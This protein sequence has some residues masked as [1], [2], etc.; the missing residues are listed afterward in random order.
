MAMTPEM[1]WEACLGQLRMDMSKASYDTWLASAQLVSFEEHTF[2]IG[3]DNSYGRDWLESRLTTT[4]KR[5]LGGMLNCTVQVKF[6]VLSQHEVSELEDPG[7]EEDNASQ[8]EQD[9]LEIEEVI[10]SLRSLLSRPDR[11][12]AVPKYLLRWLPMIGTDAFWMVIAFR[13]ARF[14]NTIPAHRHKAFT[15]R[16]EEI[17]RSC[18]MSRATFWRNID[19]P[20]LGWFIE[21]LPQTGWGLNAETG[22]AKQNPNRYRFQ[23]DIPLTPMDA[24]DLRKF[25]LHR[26]FKANPVEAVVAALDAPLS[27]ILVYPSPKPSNEQK[28]Q[29]PRP[30]TVEDVIAD[31]L[32]DINVK[33]DILAQ[34]RELS[35]RL[36][37]K[38]LRPLENF[39]LSWYFLEEWLPRLGSG[40]AA[41]VALMRSY[42]YYNPV[43]GELRDEV[44][45]EGGYEELTQILGIERTKT[46]VEWL[47]GVINQGKQKSTLTPKAQR[48]KERINQLRKNLALF[49]Q[50][51]GYRP[52]KNGFAYKFKIKLD[53]EPLVETDELICQV[54]QRMVDQ[55]QQESSLTSLKKWLNTPYFEELASQV[56]K[57]AGSGVETLITDRVPDLRLSN[58]A[59]SG[60]ETLNPILSSGIE[61]LRQAQVPVLRLFKVLIGLRTLKPLLDLPTNTGDDKPAVEGAAWNLANL[62][63]INHVS[64]KKREALL[65]Q[66]ISGTP[67]VSWLLY[68]ASSR[69]EAIKD[70]VSVAISKLLENPRE[71]A[72]GAYDRLAELL[73]EQLRNL[74]WDEL[75]L[76]RPSN[77]DWRQVMENAPRHRLR[78]LAEELGIELPAEENGW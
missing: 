39:Q 77:R 14:L 37:E 35:I 1:A 21:R 53:A 43:T 67:F 31:L 76:N 62:M 30:Q 13:Q 65:A 25:L 52:D 48:E 63:A 22:R 24:N 45:I 10:G 54:V 6:I 64:Q 56:E 32:T 40:P 11:V 26:N 27:D 61:T 3:T 46:L 4:F 78:Q 28:A 70:P 36:G 23:V 2:I 12:V 38:I 66:E 59:S 74:V 47:P 19:R 34:V 71:G 72:G 68:A 8:P 9:S 73:D 75:N 50:R 44:W 42:G 17:Y 51:L 33:G 15:A 16:A 57:G 18:G 58:D 7:D 60:F 41:L 55:C 69:G 20:E 5:L 49:V 29:V